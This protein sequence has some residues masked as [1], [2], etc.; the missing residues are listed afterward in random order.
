MKE[1]ELQYCLP[2]PVVWGTIVIEQVL[3]AETLNTIKL[4][5]SEEGVVR[6]RKHRLVT[7]TE[8]VPLALVSNWRGDVCNA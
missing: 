8:W 1:T 7:N 2:L 6:L 3:S 4:S 5:W